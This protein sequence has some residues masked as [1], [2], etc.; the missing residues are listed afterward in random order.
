MGSAGPKPT[1]H[2]DRM[3]QSMEIAAFNPK[4]GLLVISEILTITLAF[5]EDILH[6]F[7]RKKELWSRFSYQKLA[8]GMQRLPDE[9]LALRYLLESI[10]K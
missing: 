3:M 9:L 5:I 10:E 7:R 1:C 2:G 4:S 8:D 6:R